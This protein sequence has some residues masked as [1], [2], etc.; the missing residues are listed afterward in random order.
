MTV[1]NRPKNRKATALIPIGMMFLAMGLMLPYLIHPSS[2]LGLNLSHGVRGL[3]VGI[4][5]GISLPAAILARRQ[6]RCD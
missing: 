5:V 1:P 3:L 4:S 2:Q 6:R